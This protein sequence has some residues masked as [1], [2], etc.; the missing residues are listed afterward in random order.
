MTFLAPD[1]FDAYFAALI[2][3]GPSCW[4]DYL[5]DQTWTP[6][7]TFALVQAGVK[8]FPDGLKVARGHRDSYGRSEYLTLDVAITDSSWGPPLFIAEHEN[9]PYPEKIKYD[10]WK[11]LV[12][13]AKRRVLVGYFGPGTKIQTFEELRAAVEEVCRDNP[14]KDILLIGGEWAAVPKSAEELRKVYQTAIV[15]VHTVTV[16]AT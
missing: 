5:Q 11:L 16:G 1:I 4:R 13:E 9:A 12:T 15:G 3:M 14:G 8:A 7:A 2:E 6:R 10:A